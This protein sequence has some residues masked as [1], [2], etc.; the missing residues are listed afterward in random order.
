M[1]R[2]SRSAY[3]EKRQTREARLFGSIRDAD[4]ARDRREA[5]QARQADARR[6][7]RGFV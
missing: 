6:A 5:E 2:L 3:I 4:P 7:Q 1:G